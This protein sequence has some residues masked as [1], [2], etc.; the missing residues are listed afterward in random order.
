MSVLCAMCCVWIHW[1]VATVVSE[2]GVLAGMYGSL[3]AC[4]K[5]ARGLLLSLRSYEEATSSLLG[6]YLRNA[7]TSALSH[8][9]PVMRAREI[10]RWA[11]SPQYKNLLAK[12]KFHRVSSLTCTPW[13][14]QQWLG[15]RRV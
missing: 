4:L 8:P 10:D 14:G 7:Q 13:E 6:W 9:L 3:V 12:N 15:L 1:L 11:Q 5:T 2:V